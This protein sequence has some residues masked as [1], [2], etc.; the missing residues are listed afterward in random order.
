VVS[1]GGEWPESNSPH[2]WRALIDQADAEL[3]EALLWRYA[4]E[5]DGDARCIRRLCD[6]LLGEGPPRFVEVGA[7][8]VVE[9][10]NCRGGNDG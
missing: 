2:V 7:G 9:L 1:G 4:V 8:Q 6:E 5:L 10:N 3:E